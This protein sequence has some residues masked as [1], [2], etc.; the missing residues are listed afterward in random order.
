MGWV[1]AIRDE[2]DRA[3]FCGF[4]LWPGAAKFASCVFTRR[5]AM[6]PTCPQFGDRQSLSDDPANKRE[7]LR[8]I[9]LMSRSGA[10]I[11]MA[12]AMPYLDI[13]KCREWTLLRLPPIK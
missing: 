10:D 4:P 1:A 6:W 2:L 3:G 9:D 12:A 11:I 5:F 8:E 13:I 7:V